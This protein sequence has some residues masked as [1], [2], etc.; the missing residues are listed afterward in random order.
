MKYQEALEW[1][2]STQHFGIKLGL[3]VTRKVLR[4]FLAFPDY[5]VKVVHVAGTNGKGSTCAMLDALG[6]AAGLK[7]GLFTSPHLIHYR[8]RIRVAGEM[9][10]EEEVARY[11]TELKEL[12]QGWPQHPTFFELS[13]VIAM[14]YFRECGCEMIILETGMGGRFDATTAVPA[15]V[16]VITPVGMDHSEWLGET[17]E[18]IAAEKAGIIVEGKAVVVAEQDPEA[19]GVIMEVANERRSPV[20]VV[21]GELLGYT[22]NLVGA[23]QKRNAHLAVTAAHE[24]GI[25]LKYDTVKSALETIVWPGRFEKIWEFEHKRVGSTVVVD[26]AHNPQA[27]RA[28]VKTWEEEYSGVK[29]VVIFGAV[30]GKDVGE[31]L[32]ILTGIAEEII[33][34][35]I[36]NPRSL[37]PLELAKSLPEGFS[38]V[39]EVGSLEEAWE[40]ARGE[41]ILVVGSLFLVGQWKAA[42]ENMSFETS[43]Q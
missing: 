32:K 16:C 33:L 4:Q 12:V 9:I 41:Y 40:R 3:D 28:L 2:Y 20:E 6:C 8:E 11:I 13:L 31:V 43:R 26:G 35:P 38:R 17:L 29:P 21:E 42:I 36:D 18:E 7:V 39:S 27:A 10:S 24:L 37:S 22:V 5:G 30:D 23:H 14:K 34:S 19:L 25:D 15:D 1:L